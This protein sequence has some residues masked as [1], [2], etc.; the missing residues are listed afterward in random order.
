VKYREKRKEGRREGEGQRKE[1]K[2]RPDQADPWLNSQGESG[3]KGGLGLVAW[4]KN[5]P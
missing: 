1:Q 2:I 5:L 3:R 4:N